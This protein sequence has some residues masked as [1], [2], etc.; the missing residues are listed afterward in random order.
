[1]EI[2]NEKLDKKELDS[3]NKIIDDIYNSNKKVIFT[4]GKGGKG[5][6]LLEF[7]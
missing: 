7:I 5:D 3:L 1:M 2:N 6:K 4:M